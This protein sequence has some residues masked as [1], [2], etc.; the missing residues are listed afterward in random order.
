MKTMN[1]NLSLM[2]KSAFNVNRSRNEA[3]S[4]VAVVLACLLSSM[5]LLSLPV[6]HSIA[7]TTRSFSVAE[8]PSLVCF[9][10]IQTFFVV[11]HVTSDFPA[12]MDILR[13]RLHMYY[14]PHCTCFVSINVPLVY[15]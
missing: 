9:L 8:S 13:I 14:C 1:I 6:C 5:W 15:V 12:L 10:L 3:L 2:C 11:Y 7:V 4:S